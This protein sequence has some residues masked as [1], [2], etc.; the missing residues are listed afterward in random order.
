MKKGAQLLTTIV[1]ALL[2][3][4]FTQ[5]TTTA[6]TG[7]LVSRTVQ[8]RGVDAAIWGIAILSFDSMRQTGGT[9]TASVPPWVRQHQRHHTWLW[10][11]LKWNEGVN[12]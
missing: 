3:L 9:P 1:V 12:N 7:E 11:P 6:S 4:A 2:S 10:R 8:R 5:M